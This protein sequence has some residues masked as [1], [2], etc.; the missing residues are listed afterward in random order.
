M[1]SGYGKD[2]PTAALG[3]I[4][5]HTRCLSHLSGE[6][7]HTVTTC[8]A[9]PLSDPDCQANALTAVLERFARIGSGLAN[10]LTGPRFDSQDGLGD[11]SGRCKGAADKSASALLHYQLT[12]INNL[13]ICHL[14]VRIR[15][16]P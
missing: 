16:I 15:S 7:E 6:H 2:R 3:D 13:L 11:V 14:I 5:D 1:G 9:E 4:E 10:A 12:C 8:L